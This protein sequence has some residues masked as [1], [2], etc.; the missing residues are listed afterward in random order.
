M[1]DKHAVLYKPSVYY[2]QIPLINNITDKILNMGLFGTSGIRDICPQ[3]VSSNLALN[4]GSILAGWGDTLV[5]GYDGR[6]TGSMLVCAL[7]AGA[8]QNGVDIIDIGFC[9][10]PTLANYTHIRHC[11]GAM[12]TASHNP[13][14]YN[15]IKLF[16]N[17]AELAKD[18][19]EKIGKLLQEALK[20]GSSP[21]HT[22]WTDTGSKSSQH[23][24]ARE[25]HLKVISDNIDTSLIKAKNPKIV[26]DAGHL[27]GCSLT[28][29]ML[30]SIG[31]NVISINDSIGEPFNRIL[32]PNEKSLGQ[33]CKRV[34]DENADLGIAHDG[35]A[36]RSVIV[37]ETGKILGLDTQLAIAVEN[38]LKQTN[39]KNKIIVSTV[40]SSLSLA[41]VCKEN[42][43]ELDI[44]PVGSLHVARRMKEVHALFGGE[45]C[46]EYIFSKGVH[47]PDGLMA[48]FFFVQLFCKEG[49]LSKLASQIKSYPMHRDKIACANEKKADAMNKIISGWPFADSIL[50]DGIRST[51]ENGWIMVRPSGTEPIIRITAEAREEKILSDMV[52]RARE[53]VE[54]SIN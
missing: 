31:C 3:K 6:S 32:E 48:A 16:S 53:L 14:Q 50:V 11:L 49:K 42:G 20:A 7:G 10:T 43:A 44:T 19:E 45:P 25:A 34:V 52:D 18:A 23:I 8:M 13:A 37:D 33:L 41:Q 40:E 30:E 22:D 17:G 4:L 15:G 9:T 29:E 1:Q 27:S 39:S 36:D 24:S 46:G 21:L 26:L 28:K 47:A 51:M 38:I 12:I 5:I 54:S 35:D 2:Y